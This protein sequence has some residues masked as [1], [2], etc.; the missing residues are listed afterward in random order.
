M[1][2][3]DFL[4]HGAVIVHAPWGVVRSLTS[5]IS[6]FQTF[7]WLTK[8]ELGFR[9]LVRRHEAREMFRK[10]RKVVCFCTTYVGG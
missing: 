3:I 5:H 8:G 10:R 2:L 6:P 9:W 4:T 7:S 1:N